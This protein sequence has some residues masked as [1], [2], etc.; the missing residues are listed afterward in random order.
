MTAF[1]VAHVRSVEFGPDIVAYL[2]RID[3]TL[4]PFGGRFVVHGGDVEVVE[5]SWGK[6]LI[7]IEFPDL[8]RLRAWY[9]SP[10]YRAILPLRTEHMEADIV[11]AQGVPA[12]YRAA[13]ALEH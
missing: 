5:G 13:S 4:D 12:D 8:D 1:A 3:A 10:A 2:E 11:F 9:D 6:D 7:I